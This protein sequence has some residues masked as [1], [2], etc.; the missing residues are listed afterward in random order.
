[1]NFLYNFLQASLQVLNAAPRTGGDLLHHLCDLSGLVRG[2][3][4]TTLAT[5]PVRGVGQAVS[6]QT[7]APAA[8]DWAEESAGECAQL[9]GVATPPT[10]TVEV[11][12]LFEGRSPHDAAETAG[13]VAGGDLLARLDVGD[14]QQTEG[15]VPGHSPMWSWGMSWFL[16][17]TN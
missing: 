1:M 5:P 2:D 12:E 14:G 9:C 15:V 4:P 10:P 7:V 3:I 11:P 13:L 8:G 6:G 16:T 17:T